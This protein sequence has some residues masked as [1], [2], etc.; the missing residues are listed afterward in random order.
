ME[1]AK[2][3]FLLQWLDLLWNSLEAQCY[4]MMDP[5]QVDVL[6]IGY[7]KTHHKS[8]QWQPQT[9]FFF[10]PDILF[11]SFNGGFVG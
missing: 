6:W 4:K 11:T 3:A 7:I 2:Q 8:S 10:W 9:F 1:A 5:I